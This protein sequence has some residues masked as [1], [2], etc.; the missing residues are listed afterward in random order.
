MERILDAVNSSHNAVLRGL[1]IPYP[2][3]PVLRPF[4]ERTRLRDHLGCRVTAGFCDKAY[5]PWEERICGAA[6]PPSMRAEYLEVLRWAKAI[7]SRLLAA[8]DTSARRCMSTIPL[9]G[10]AAIQQ[11]TRC[12][13]P[14][15]TDGGCMRCAPGRRSRLAQRRE[16]R[17]LMINGL[18]NREFAG[19][20]VPAASRFGSGTAAALHRHQPDAAHA[21]CPR[22]D[23]E[24][25]AYAPLS[26]H[27]P[28]LLSILT[29]ARTR[30]QQRNQLTEQAA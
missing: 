18:R 9:R 29:T 26:G 17:R 27:R 4:V 20:A 11:P 12:N 30:L 1:C 8:C 3:S 16:Q 13:P 6:K 25:A 28:T 7:R 15:A 22:P 10:G 23:P 2:R 24:S 14:A 5:S 19:S 21:A